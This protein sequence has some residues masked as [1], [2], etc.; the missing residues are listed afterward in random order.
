MQTIMLI[1]IAPAVPPFA[2]EK[3]LVTTPNSQVLPSTTTQAAM[4]TAKMSEPVLPVLTKGYQGQA[5][6]TISE[7]PL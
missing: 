3:V 7:T 5:A 4:E 1:H 2:M 6:L